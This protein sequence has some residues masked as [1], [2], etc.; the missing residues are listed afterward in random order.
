LNLGFAAD[1]RVQDALVHNGLTNSQEILEPLGLTWPENLRDPN[2]INRA[3]EAASKLGDLKPDQSLN[4]R[5]MLL[6][7]N[8]DVGV[9]DFY[10][11]SFRLFGLKVQGFFWT[12]L[13]ILALSYGLAVIA[14][15]RRPT[16]ILFF[17]CFLFAHFCTVAY[18]GIAYVDPDLNLSAIHNS[19]FMSVLALIPTL[20]LLLALMKPPRASITAVLAAAVQILLLM[21]I[22]TI[23]GA[24]SIYVAGLLC[25]VLYR[26][27]IECRLG[28]RGK[29]FAAMVKSCLIW[30]VV[31]V[32][33]GIGAFNLYR[34]AEL[35][36]AYTVIDEY[37]PNHYLWHSMIIGLTV[38][39]NSDQWFRDEY[40][41]GWG[42]HLP[43]A[44]MD[45]YLKKY[46]LDHTYVNDAFGGRF[47]TY[48]NLNRV[49]F[50]EFVKTYPGYTLRIMLIDKPLYFIYL[51]IYYLS[52]FVI[53]ATCWVLGAG[54]IIVASIAVWL[55]SHRH[56]IE[57][58]NTILPIGFVGA[59]SFTPMVLF[60][61]APHIMGDAIYGAAAMAAV[62]FCMGV[63]KVWMR[64]FR[65]LMSTIPFPLVTI[66]RQELTARLS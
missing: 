37:H 6:A 59:L 8:E 47:N 51:L 55:S 10:K 40:Q 57:P 1:S 5:R 18:V 45:K 49:T 22:V 15:W 24:A 4:P 32:V 41:T 43:S 13:I 2:V 62:L 64:R 9:I 27:W 65:A 16:A 31:V 14:Y 56:C 25:L 53:N 21:F 63:R 35:N 42:D 7:E 30:P 52:G 23:R 29:P 50:F 20:H 17:N 36:P 48:E 19:R 44:F 61:A 26:V 46:G 12:Y 28:W 54:A 11:L 58:T 60:Y 34:S 38:N 66:R 39:Q 3:M 33:T